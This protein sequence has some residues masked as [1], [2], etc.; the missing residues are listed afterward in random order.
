MMTAP[1]QVQV[2]DTARVAVLEKYAILD[3]EP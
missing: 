2:S 3:T 1:K